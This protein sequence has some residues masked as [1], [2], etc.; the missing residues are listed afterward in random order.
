[1]FVLIIK[2]KI[3]LTL[4]NDKCIIFIEQRSKKYITVFLTL[5]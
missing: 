4:Y 2:S 5:P 1:L 3:S